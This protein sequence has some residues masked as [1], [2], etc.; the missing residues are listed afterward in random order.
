MRTKEQLLSLDH[1][2]PV[3]CRVVSENLWA[4]YPPVQPDEDEVEEERQ[5]QE[6]LR[7]QQVGRGGRCWRGG[8]RGG[9][10]QADAE[11]TA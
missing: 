11:G 2:G 10:L 9:G 1:V 8:G 7:R 5:I 3:I 4:L 6:A